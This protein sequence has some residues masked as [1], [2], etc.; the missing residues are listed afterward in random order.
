MTGDTAASISTSDGI[1]FTKVADTATANPAQ[2]WVSNSGMAGNSIT[3]TINTSASTPSGLAADVISVSGMNSYGSSAV[4]QASNADSGLGGASIDPVF[5]VSVQSAN[6][7]LGIVANATNPATQLEP[8]G[9]TESADIGYATPTRGIETIFR[10]SGFSGTTITW[11]DTASSVFS[12]IA[13]ELN[14]SA[15]VSLFM[16][17]GVGT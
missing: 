3:V 11:G 9:W 5:P 13:V 12:A 2:I 1:A 7:T 17:L 16:L 15:S 14:A 6:P 4:I 10:N 8:S